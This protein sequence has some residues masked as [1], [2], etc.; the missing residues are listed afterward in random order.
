M[1]Q[2]LERA[3]LCC[4]TPPLSTKMAPLGEADDMARSGRGILQNFMGAK[5]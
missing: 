5:Q 2:E 1:D 3:A 4:A